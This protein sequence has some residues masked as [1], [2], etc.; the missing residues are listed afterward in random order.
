MLRTTKLALTVSV[1]ALVLASAVTTA[2]ANRLSVSNQNIRVVWNPLSFGAE[3]GAETI[4]CRVTLEGSFHSRTIVKTIG[5]LIGAITRAIVGHPCTGPFGFGAEGWA[6]NGTESILGTRSTNTLP[7]H[8]SYEGFEGTL[9]NLNRVNLLLT[10]LRFWLSIPIGG[11]LGRYGGPTANIR[12]FAEITQPGGTV[13]G[14]TPEPNA[15]LPLVEGSEGCPNPGFFS[16][17]GTVSLLGNTTP[18]TITLI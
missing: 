18:I 11:C 17:R 16:R 2:S 7:W 10:G 15:S 8:I 9:P 6:E 4:R 5:N 1:A 3:A 14:L 12:G 13:A